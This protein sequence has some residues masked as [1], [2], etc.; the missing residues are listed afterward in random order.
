MSRCPVIGAECNYCHKKNH[1]ISVCRKRQNKVKLIDDEQSDSQ[2]LSEAS[3]PSISSNECDVLFGFKISDGK[4]VPKKCITLNCV[5]VYVLIDSGSSLNIISEIDLK[6]MKIRQ[7]I[8]KTKTKAFAFGQTSPLPFIGI[9]FLLV[10]SKFIT[11][12]H[13]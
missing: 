9:Y 12:D 8:K 5:D 7:E 11:K 2:V 4:K 6:K 3:T 10:E 1:F 13:Q